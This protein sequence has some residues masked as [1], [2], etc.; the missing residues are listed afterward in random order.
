MPSAKLP[1]NGIERYHPHSGFVG[2]GPFC[3]A[4]SKVVERSGTDIR[5]CF[6]CQSCSGYPVSWAMAYRPN[7]VARVLPLG[8]MREALHSSDIWYCIGW[9]FAVAPRLLIEC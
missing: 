2:A 3:D 9:E 7:G 1:P 5:R 4:I 8:R 6:P